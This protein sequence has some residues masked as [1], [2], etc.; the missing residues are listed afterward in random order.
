MGI[1][2]LCK[3][4]PYETLPKHGKVQLQDAKAKKEEAKE[5]KKKAETAAETE[6]TQV[7]GG[8]RQKPRQSGPKATKEKPRATWAEHQLLEDT[9]LNE[10]TTTGAEAQSSRPKR[11][12][13]RGK[14]V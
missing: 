9:K 8:T 3:R 13:G 12:C 4:T 10:E 1:E 6:F 5:E 14:R 11:S 7:R 2:G